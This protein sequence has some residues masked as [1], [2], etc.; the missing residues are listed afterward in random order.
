MGFPHVKTFEERLSE[1]R[2]AQ[3]TRANGLS[4]DITPELLA[5]V[6]KVIQRHREIQGAPIIQRG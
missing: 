1:V 5:D 6:R 4:V 2:R 3:A